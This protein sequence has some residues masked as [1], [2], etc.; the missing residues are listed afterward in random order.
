MLNESLNEAPGNKD[1]NIKAIISS[2]AL[3]N[4]H[5]SGPDFYY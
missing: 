5:A 4:E 1:V 2:A 3:S